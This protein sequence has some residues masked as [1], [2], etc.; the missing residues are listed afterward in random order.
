MHFFG[1]NPVFYSFYTRCAA[2]R[3]AAAAGE[4]VALSGMALATTED[5]TPSA[6]HVPLSAQDGAFEKCTVWVG[7]I[8]HGNCTPACLADYFSQ[9]GE[10]V[11]AR[12]RQKE[13]K[14][15]DEWPY[16]SW[17][18]V[19]FASHAQ[20]QKVIADRRKLRFYGTKVTI[21][22]AELEAHEGDEGSSWNHWHKAKQEALDALA[23]KRHPAALV[24]MPPPAKK[25]FKRKP[26]PLDDMPYH[27]APRHKEVR[28]TTIWSR[29]VRRHDCRHDAYNCVGPSLPPRI[30]ARL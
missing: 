27:K 1:E 19:T 2:A 30:L 15:G 6:K 18:F 10:V 16:R 25:G 28:L 14:V 22:Q 26:K 11:N 12:C 29:S 20:Q 24:N 5:A 13:D 17:A 7:H 9:Y 3:R 4:Q 8:Q 23:E 21:D